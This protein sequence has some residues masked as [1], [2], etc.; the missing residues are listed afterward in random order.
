MTKHFLDIFY[1][2]FLLHIIIYALFSKR[3]ELQRGQR[4][5]R[6]EG[7]S[8]QGGPAAQSFSAI[9]YLGY[10]VKTYKNSGM[11]SDHYQ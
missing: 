6:Q 4:P 5:V 7:G 2:L 9:V 10:S 11:V 3:Q 8:F 1:T